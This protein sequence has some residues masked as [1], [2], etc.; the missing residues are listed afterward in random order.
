MSSVSSLGSLAQ[1]WQQGTVDWEYPLVLLPS[2]YVK[3]EHSGALP[4]LLFFSPLTSS[5]YCSGA[6]MCFGVEMTKHSC[7]IPNISDRHH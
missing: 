5:A 1:C 6:H 4:S 3:V 7:Q 2:A